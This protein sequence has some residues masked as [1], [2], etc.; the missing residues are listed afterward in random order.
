MLSKWVTKAGSKFEPRK[1]TRKKNETILHGDNFH[2]TM[3]TLSTF[4][5]SIKKRLNVCPMYVSTK[6]NQVKVW[7][8]SRPCLCVLFVPTRNSRDTFRDYCHQHP[9]DISHTVHRPLVVLAIHHSARAKRHCRQ[10]TTTRPQRAT[11]NVN[12]SPLCHL[13]TFNKHKICTLHLLFLPVCH[14]AGSSRRVGKLSLVLWQS[15][16]F[17]RVPG[18]R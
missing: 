2:C 14:R 17:A 18:N 6:R 8:Y 15:L 11:N 4:Q 5:E 7:N 10:A 9:N 1:S 12:F 13:F 3:A 16:V